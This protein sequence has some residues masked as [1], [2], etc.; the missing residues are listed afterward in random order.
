MLGA[1]FH[2][3]P[4]IVSQVREREEQLAFGVPE[5]RLGGH[6]FHTY[7]LKSKDGT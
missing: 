7:S 6:A 3:L 4:R 5:E 2:V 1:C